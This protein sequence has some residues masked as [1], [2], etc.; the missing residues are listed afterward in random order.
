MRISFQVIISVL[1]VGLFATSIAAPW[2]SRSAS[3]RLVP[4]EQCRRIVSLAPSTTEALFAVGLGDRVVGVSRFCDY[5]PE[6]A[7]R[8]AVGGYADLNYEAVLAVRPDLVVALK[9]HRIHQRNLHQLGIP[10]LLVDHQSLEGVWESLKILDDVC[11]ADGRGRL[12]AEQIRRRLDQVQQ[13]FAG[14]R[15]PRVLLVL[16][17]EGSSHRVSACRVVGREGYFDRMIELAGGINACGDTWIRYPMVSAEGLLAMAPEVIIDM[18]PAARPEGALP[19]TANDATIATGAFS[20]DKRLA[21]W[22]SLPS[23]PAVQQGHVFALHADYA[24]RPGPR[25]IET[26][27][28]IASLLHPERHGRQPTGAAAPGREPA[29]SGR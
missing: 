28:T 26:I 12:L 9:E 23:L 15:R 19:N 21:A 7:S 8:P 18:S 17:R 27:E 22:Q 2:F 14:C 10:T 4:P 3:C 6:A 24:F 1:A 29:S 16:E 13:K 11:H 25:V 5:P 20:A